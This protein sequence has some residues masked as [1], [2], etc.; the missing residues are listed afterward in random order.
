MWGLWSG[1]PPSLGDRPGT[2]TRNPQINSG[3]VWSKPVIYRQKSLKYRRISAKTGFC[4]SIFA[5]SVYSFYVIHNQITTKPF[6]MAGCIAVAID[7]F[8]LVIKK[9]SLEES[10]YFRWTSRLGF[11][12]FKPKINWRLLMRGQIL[13]MFFLIVVFLNALFLGY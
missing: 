3:W 5:F 4:A 8:L 1:L 6:V 12:G 9:P 7:S 11:F 13:I 2:W 10:P